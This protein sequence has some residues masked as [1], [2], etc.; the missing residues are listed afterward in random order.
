VEASRAAGDKKL[1]PELQ[2]SST[3]YYSDP[4][5][6]WFRRFLEKSEATRPKTCF[7]SFRHCFRDA[8][9]E[10]RID[11]DVALALGGWSS[12]SGKEGVETAESYGQGFRVATLF[13]AIKRADYP[14]LDLGHL[15][16]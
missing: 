11:H 12:A 7:H 13:E 14:D 6:K 1:F 10:A 16:S 5:S 8:L 9:R 4:F 2:A 15:V 3:G